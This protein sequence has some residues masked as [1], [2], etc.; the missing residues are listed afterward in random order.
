MPCDDMKRNGTAPPAAPASKKT[1]ERSSLDE[2]YRKLSTVYSILP[3][4]PEKN[5]K[6]IGTH[7]GTFHCDDALA[8]AMLQL[9]PEYEG[10]TVVRTRD[11]SALDKCS[12]VVDVGNVY[13][14]SKLRY[15]HHQ[16]SFSDNLKEAGFSTKL[17]ACGLVYRHYGMQL[18]RSITT[19]AIG[20]ALPEAVVAMMYRKVYA[21]FMEHIDAIDNGVPVCVSGSPQYA[22]STSLSSRVAHLNP[23]WNQLSTTEIRNGLFLQA[24]HLTGREFVDHI[25]RLATS[26][27]PARDLVAKAV[28][29]KTQTMPAAKGQAIL[30]ESYCPWSGHLADL[31]REQ[32]MGPVIKYV[33]F[34]DSKGT[35]WRVQ[36]VPES[37]GS[38]ISRKALPASWRG[39][40]N[41]ELDTASG[42]AGCVFVHASGFIGGHTTRDG[43]VK[44]ALAALDAA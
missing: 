2:I 22:V 6:T 14:H 25:A 26:W 9:L 29:A 4:V 11:N 43:A 28:L 32:K 24:M 12:I 19:A 40:R 42:I 17:S 20:S 13:D 16:R 36:A 34:K 1:C 38:F 41:T 30:F 27:W 37:E 3:T 33:L 44:M 31:E 35:S 8:C 15:D 7:N 5:G 39:L 10:S 21:G 23:R 18:L